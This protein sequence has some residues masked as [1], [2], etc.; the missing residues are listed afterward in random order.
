MLLKDFQ[1]SS[2]VETKFQHDRTSYPLSKKQEL[3]LYRVLQES[4]TNVSKYAKATRVDVSIT[5]MESSF[6][7]RIKDDGEGFDMRC[8]KGARGTGLLGMEERVEKVG[9]SFEVRSAR[10]MGTEIIVNIKT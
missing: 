9:G 7:M 10:G 8:G 1:D 2:K 6:R 5:A 3:C 4:L